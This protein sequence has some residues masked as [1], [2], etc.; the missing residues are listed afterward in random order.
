MYVSSHLEKEDKNE[1]TQ[2][3]TIFLTPSHPDSQSI[4]ARIR[5]V[6]VFL[7]SELPDPLVSPVGDVRL[8][9][10]LA[11]LSVCCCVDAHDC[12]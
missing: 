1:H 9:C 8:K 10:L 6:Y 12:P 5:L 2:H 3:P 7:A 4:L 11:M